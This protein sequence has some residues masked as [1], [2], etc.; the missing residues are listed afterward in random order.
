M[1]GAMEKVFRTIVV[2]NLAAFLIWFFQPYGYLTITDKS[3][4][5]ALAWNGYGGNEILNQY[6]PW[7]FLA[8]SLICAVGL[9]FYLNFARILFALMVL[10]ALLLSPFM[11]LNIG[12]GIDTFFHTL[13]NLLDGIILFMSYFSSISNKFSSK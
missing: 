1:R 12:T 10:S 6:I 9:Y 5:D 4:M 3:V 7:C 2:I 8:V 11:G 13:I